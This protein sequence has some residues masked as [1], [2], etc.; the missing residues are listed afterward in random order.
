MM[1]TYTIPIRVIVLGR[2]KTEVAMSPAEAMRKVEIASLQCERQGLN[3]K[4]MAVTLQITRIFLDLPKWRWWSVL[5]SAFR[6]FSKH[7]EDHMLTAFVV[8]AMGGRDG[9]CCPWSNWFI[10]GSRAISG[11]W[12]HEMLHL[13][14]KWTHDSDP[15]NVMHKDVGFKIR[16]EQ[17]A[18]L[19]ASRFAHEDKTKVAP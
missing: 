15:E 2:S 11:A 6:W 19:K 5:S 17:I 13:A 8:R 12:L 1:A 4:W 16:P 3:I 18:R 7:A 9:W 10:V 14:G